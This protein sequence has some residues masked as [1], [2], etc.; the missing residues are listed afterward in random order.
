M[1]LNAAHS[2]LFQITPHPHTP[3]A[4]FS[5]FLNAGDKKYKSDETLLLLMAGEYSSTGVLVRLVLY[6][7]CCQICQNDSS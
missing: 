3:V 6:S 2:A 1:V 7:D 4:L 5:L